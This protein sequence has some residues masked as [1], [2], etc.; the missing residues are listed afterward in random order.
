MDEFQLRC[1]RGESV[2]LYIVATA[3]VYTVFQFL[4]ARL[5]LSESK[6]VE[7]AF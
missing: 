1:G 5:L 7:S 3:M 2:L 6:A 4:K